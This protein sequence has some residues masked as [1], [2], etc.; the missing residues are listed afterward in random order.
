MRNLQLFAGGPKPDLDLIWRRLQLSFE[1]SFVTGSFSA[2][3]N[4]AQLRP[5]HHQ[6]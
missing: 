4:R 1:V 2:S 3:S 5:G 6:R